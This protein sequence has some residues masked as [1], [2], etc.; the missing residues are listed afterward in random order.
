MN[1][2]VMICQVSFSLLTLIRVH[3]RI[4][5]HKYSVT[6]KHVRD[7]S[8]EITS[9]KNYFRIKVMQ[10]KTRVLNSR[11]AIHAPLKTIAE[12]AI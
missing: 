9:D 3:R 10:R 4:E 7:H 5:E 8:V 12:H 1:H 11:D 2:T 6:G